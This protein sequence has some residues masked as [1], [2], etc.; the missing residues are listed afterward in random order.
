MSKLFSS[1]QLG[2]LTLA[3]RIVIAPM[4]QYSAIDGAATDWHMMH[5]G[6]LAI[7]GAGM[8]L[9]EATAVSAEGRITHGDLG[10]YSRDAEMAIGKVVSA[11]RT[12]SPILI[13]M[14]L[15]HAGRKGSC[16]VPN[17]SLSKRR[18]AG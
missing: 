12:Y 2:G 15:A 10:I 1:Y 16:M 6:Q 13:G 11:I 18:T 5:L 17:R 14:Q 9:I 7:S 3:N 8:M 4:C